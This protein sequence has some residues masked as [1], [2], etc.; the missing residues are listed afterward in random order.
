MR[1]LFS[2]NLRL[3][4]EVECLQKKKLRDKSSLGGI[5]NFK[6]E[7]LISSNFFVLYSG[8]FVEH[9]SWTS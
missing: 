1:K 6:L 3:F 4:R 5:F 2:I 9:L 7:R 8:G